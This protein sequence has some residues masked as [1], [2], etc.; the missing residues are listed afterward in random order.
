MRGD[1][2]EEYVE[3]VQESGARPARAWYRRQARRMVVDYVLRHRVR[4]DRRVGTDIRAAGVARRGAG[5]G[6]GQFVADA[7][8]T[9][10]GFRR[11]PGLFL[12]VIA[13]LALGIGANTA[14]YSVVRAVVLEPLP[15]PEP[16][17]VVRVKQTMGDWLDHSNPILDR[18]ANDFPVEWGVLLDWERLNQSFDAIGAYDQQRY[19][20]TGPSRP[21]WIGGAQVSSGVFRVLGVQPAIGRVF[22]SDDDRV[23]GERTVLL[24]HAFWTTAFG[25]DPAV[26]GTTITL[27]GERHR[28]IGVMP[29]DFY[30]PTRAVAL[31]TRLSDSSLQVYQGGQS[32]HAVA[33]LS[34]GTSIEQARLDMA[35]VS[36]RILE[37]R[38]ER[39]RSYGV[40]VWSQHE[41]LVGDVRPVMTM[42]L[43]AVGAVLLIACANASG[44]ML[45]RATRRRR[46]IAL[47]VSLGAGRRRILGQLLTESVLLAL[48]AG[49]AAIA[50]TALT[51]Q[52]LVS[53][54]PAEI[55]R[56]GAIHLDARVLL[57]SI[58]ATLT[59]GLLVGVLPAVRAM[60]SG[61]A[62]VLRGGGR[63]S[64][65]GRDRLRAQRLLVVAEV[66]LTV[67]LVVGAG[68][69]AGSLG[70]MS[71]VDIG[72]DP[73]GVLSLQASLYGDRYDSSEKLRMFYTTLRERLVS[74]PGTQ[75]VAAG[76][77]SPFGEG[78]SGNTLRVGRGD[79]VVES[80]VKWT[81]VDGPFFK[82]FGIPILA[83]RSFEEADRDRSDGVA[84]INEAM[85]RE[86]WPASDPLGQVF[87]EGSQGGV[88]YRIV[89]IAG[90]V[91]RGSPDA[92]A[93]SLVYLPG[94]TPHMTFVKSAGDLPGFRASVERVVRG[95]DPDVPLTIMSLE[96]SVRISTAAPRFRALLVGMFAVLA[97]TLALVGVG[98]ILSYAVTQQ[99]REIGLRMA[100][101]ATAHR[102]M[103]SVLGHGLRLVM[104]GLIIGG[105]IAAFAVRL[106]ESFLFETSAGDPMVLL[107]AAGLLI[108]AGL[109]VSVLPARRA[110]NVQ[111]GTILNAE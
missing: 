65:G 92:P 20:F 40:R 39:N 75:L 21:E 71:T 26:L 68:L 89:G 95:I 79:D 23:G 19:A 103:R 36:D 53:M 18:M 28:V 62:S 76:Q 38:P 47:R 110:A 101:G 59:C 99:R 27:T 33:R 77:R 73:S 88:S 13:I 11:E 109:L 91:R 97:G 106:I 29:P 70:R 82:L 43:A 48:V 34:A 1:L 58:A 52:V 98:G 5:S 56:V 6:F 8:L 61:A 94:D 44:L 3:R 66:A 46:E 50:V 63:S 96:E 104:S 15:Y 32:L 93:S 105:A 14:V 42:L 41:Y 12:T 78:G 100:L 60:R 87:Y 69:L 84:I 55:P 85:A 35:V 86:F 49:L 9:L 24:S 4:R 108:T 10:R 111:P 64:T 54:L 17:R 30:F 22:S 51:Q 37:E 72:L 90:D 31:W 74:L 81:R 67:P 57:F 83:G 45:I 16:E 25:G 7:K 80:N 107:G 102:V 2:D